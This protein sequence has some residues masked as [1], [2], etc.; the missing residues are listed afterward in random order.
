MKDR[1]SSLLYRV[2]VAACLAL[3]C[4]PSLMAQE[5]EASPA[6]AAS[7]DRTVSP[8]TRNASPEARAL[9]KFFYG[10][11]GE[12]LLTG[13]H[14][15]PN[16]KG[17]NSQFAAKYIGKTPVIYG[18][19]WGFA[20]DGNSDAFHSRQDIVEEAIRQ[21]KLGSIITICWHAVPPTANEPVTFQPL[22]GADPAHLASVQGKLLDDQFKDVLTPG[23]ELYQHWC[24]Q[25]D[26]IAY[27]LKELQA[28]HV[29]ILWRPYHEMNGDWF[30]WGGRTGEYSTIR[31]YRQLFDRLVNYH[32]LNNLIWLWSLDRPAL[33]GRQ[34]SL[35]NVGSD[36][37]DMA[38]LDVYGSDFSPSYYDSLL[39][40][41]KGKPIALAEVGNP[42]TPEVLKS[43]SRWTYYM[44]W[45]GMVR[46]TT[47]KQYAA[48][49]ND[50][51]VLCREDAAYLD[52]LAPYRAVAG[53]PPLV[54]RRGANFA[55]EWVFDEDRSVL[56][57]SGSGSLPGRLDVSEEADRIDIKRTMI[58]EFA[59]NSV[60]ENNLAL[61]GTEHES[62]P[63][64]GNGPGT[65]AAHRSENGDTLYIDSKATLKNGGRTSEWTNHEIW[66]LQDQGR[67]LSIG[68]TSNSF[69]GKRTLTA[70]YNKNYE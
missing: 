18:T 69:R 8:V 37:F 46:L 38:V 44:I 54:A 20:N 32:K 65:I 42:P 62:K 52:A 11:S 59:D 17:R 25:V 67:T 22:P 30:W 12:Y 28:A 16:T 1:Y 3:S 43:Q 45:A 63:P 23:T 14:N 68:Q 4:D 58:S 41:A 5:K 13:Q 48:L 34:F 70:I 55:G 36:E 56:D 27:Y 40:L 64:F 33:R 9:L 60:V 47:R 50:P 49:V 15:Y 31:L 35:Y 61:D 6:T 21:N 19:D 29:P 2:L 7:R 24:A 57:N 26:S 66:T 53:L 51:H 39:V 10:I